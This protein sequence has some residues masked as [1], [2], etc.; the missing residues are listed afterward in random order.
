[1][2]GFICILWILKH[3]D[4]V[5]SV[6]NLSIPQVCQMR[7]LEKLHLDNNVLT[8]LPRAVALQLPKLR[9]LTL[10]NNKVLIV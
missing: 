8:E 4:L 2:A 3:P 1:M 6:Y 7:S 5:Y 9:A 10:E